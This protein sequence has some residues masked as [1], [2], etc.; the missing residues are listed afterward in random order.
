M[1]KP[2]AK[3]GAFTTGS[4][5]R[6]VV[7]MTSTSSI[8]LVSIFLVDGLNLFYIALLGQQELAAAIGYAA[9]IMFFTISVCIGISISAAAL[10]GR[11]LGAGEEERARELSTLSLIYLLITTVILAAMLFPALRFFLSLLGAKGETLDL[12][13]AFMHIVVPSIPLL[14]LGM[15]LGAL[16]RAKGD[17]RRAM[18]VTLSGGAAALVL[19]PLLIFGLGLELT[20]AAIA[21]VLVR[22]ILVVVGLWGVHRVHGMLGPVRMSSATAALRPFFTIAVPAVATQLATPVGNAY[23]TAS[24]ADFGD[25]AVAGWAIVGRLLPVAFGVIFALS[26]SVGPIVSQ[27][28]GAKLFDRVN[29]TMRD[30]L[31]FTLIYCLSVWALLAVLSPYIVALFGASGNAAD[32]VTVFCLFVA[33]SF[34]FNGALF[35]AN[36]AFN[37]LGFAFYATAFNWGRATLGVVPFV[38]VGKEYGPS[39]VLI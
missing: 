9:T 5:M 30:A 1:A 8:G 33:G 19:D 2:G 21:T 7:V 36:A 31:V 26:G 23:V 35:V 4:T 25:D 15:C 16:L 28:Y 27:N 29:S 14:G 10:V 13:V 3:G 6:H 22:C 18:F 34:L 12:A 37:N 38:W 17:P 20:G 11:A 24:I 32:I 39:G